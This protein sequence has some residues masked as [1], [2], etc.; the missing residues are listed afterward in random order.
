MLIVP[1]NTREA[2]GAVL[3][4]DRDRLFDGHQHGG[5]RMVP[6]SKRLEWNMGRSG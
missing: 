6:C 3:A 2:K 5:L 1:N 4:T